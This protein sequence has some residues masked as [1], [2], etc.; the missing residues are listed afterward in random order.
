M[1]YRDTNGNG[2][3]DFV[4]SVGESDGAYTSGGA[5]T[6]DV[7][8]ITIPKSEQLR[9][10]ASVTFADQPIRNNTLIV[11]GARLPDGGFIVAHN[12]SYRRTGNPLSSA[13]VFPGTCP[14]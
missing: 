3:F 4:E 9:P 5:P 7:A 6:S 2:N 11:R 12:E 14:G 1:A 8:G 10:V 13:V